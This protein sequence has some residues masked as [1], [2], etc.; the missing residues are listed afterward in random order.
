MKKNRNQLCDCDSKK[1]YKNCC[2]KN[3]ISVKN[4]FT[5]TKILIISIILG[6]SSITIY[7][8]YDFYQSERPEMEAYECDN[9]NCGKI[10]YRP[11][12]DN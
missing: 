3:Q 4:T 11:V 9:P 6:L 1:K 2:G 5:I 10:H 8:V 12:K 7:G